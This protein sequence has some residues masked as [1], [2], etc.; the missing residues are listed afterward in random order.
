MGNTI[1]TIA[2]CLIIA[3]AASLVRTFTEFT[4]HVSFIAAE[5]ILHF[6]LLAIFF[7]LSSFGYYIW[8]MF[9]SRNVFLRVTDSRKYCY[10]SSFVWGSTF[11]LT[12]TA[13]FAHYFLEVDSYKK[14]NI[15]AEQETM[16]WLGVS[17]FFAAITSTIVIDVFFYV[18]TLKL[19]NRRNV[20][21]RIQHKLKAK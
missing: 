11:L 13:V 15:V 7:W 10:Y 17:I 9:R 6:S 2:V 5:I 3:K 18:T 21:G 20:Y 14:Q 4:N 1:T 19:I 12:A 8:K 16:G